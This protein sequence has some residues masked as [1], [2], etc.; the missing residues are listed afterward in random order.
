[1]IRLFWFVD[2][3]P[4]ID[5]GALDAM[6]GYLAG[7]RL[8]SAGLTQWGFVELDIES[9]R[10][11][12]PEPRTLGSVQLGLSRNRRC[13]LGK[14]RLDTLEPYC[15]HDHIAAVNCRVGTG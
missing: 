4:V 11:G 5:F 2:A 3:N 8:Q 10:F 6:P 1:M 13:H 14:F 15:I 7:Q 12:I 9:V